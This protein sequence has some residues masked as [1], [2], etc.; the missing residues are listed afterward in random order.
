MRT[1]ILVV[2]ILA[3]ALLARPSPAA[4]Q[5]MAPIPGQAREVAVQALRN[6]VQD[7]I[8]EGKAERFGFRSL[9]EARAATLGEPF[10][11]LFIG[12]DQ[13]RKYRPGAG[14]GSVLR[15]AR[16]AWFPVLAG[17]EPR[18]KLEVAERDGRWVGGEFGRP[19]STRE[20]MAAAASLEAARAEAGAA[21]ADR[22]ALVR[23]PALNAQLLYLKGQRGEVLVPIRREGLP[24][25]TESGK[26]YAADAFLVRLAE[27]ARKVEDKVVR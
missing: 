9:A 24:P 11:V 13:L 19:S 26:A 14:A 7:A 16:A 23:I 1:R 18:A 21:A 22:P 25:G 6:F 10:Q 27:G 15:D 8:P 20:V 2:A 5:V 12:L 3:V 4:A 17:G